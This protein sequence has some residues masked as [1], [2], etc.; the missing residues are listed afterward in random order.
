MRCPQGCGRSIEVPAEA[1]RSVYL[2]CACGFA[3]HI[4]WSGTVKAEEVEELGRAI[5]EIRDRSR[6]RRDLERTGQLTL[7][8]QRLE[9]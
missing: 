8:M 4:H 6:A 2:A 5:E 3:A 1:R 7:T 9:G